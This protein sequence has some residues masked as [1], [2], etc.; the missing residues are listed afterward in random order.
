M[1]YEIDTA[2]LSDAKRRMREEIDEIAELC[3]EC[4][5]KIDESK[6]VFDTPTSKMFRDKANDII[7]QGQQYIDGT[8]KPFIE[9]LDKVT[10]QYEDMITEI[11]K[12]T[13]NLR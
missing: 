2:K 1:R 5:R 8:V 3:T 9:S 10:R 4:Y 12:L 6:E 13:E 7:L 11:H